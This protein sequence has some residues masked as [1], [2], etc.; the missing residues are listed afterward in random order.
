MA[1]KQSPSQGLSSENSEDRPHSVRFYEAALLFSKVASDRIKQSEKNLFEIMK[2]LY[3]SHRVK[4]YLFTVITE[5]LI[6]ALWAFENT[7]KKTK[8]HTQYSRIMERTSA[9]FK[10]KNQG[11]LLRM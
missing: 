11:S 8:T 6:K 10:R 4:A 7:E 2:E 9:K 3:D 1:M 5:N